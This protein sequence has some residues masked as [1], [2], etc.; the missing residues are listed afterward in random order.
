MHITCISLNIFE[1]GLF[2]PQV[3][4]F[5]QTENPDIIALQEV[6]NEI[7]P[8]LPANLRTIQELK[9]MLPDFYCHFAPELILTKDKKKHV[10][11]N[12]IL[13]RF[14]IVEDSTTFY[15]IPFGE[16]DVNN[17][18]FAQSPKNIHCAKIK[19]N[20][21]Y[22]HVFNT[23]GIW[24]LD[25]G[26]NERRLT[27]SKT[28]INEIKGKENV[29][30]AGDFNIKPHTQTIANIEKELKNVFKDELTSTFN[31]KHKTNPGYASAVVDMIFVSPNMKVMNHYCP[32]VDVS[33]HFPLVIHVEI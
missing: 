18:D 24:G 15:D 17:S 25:G 22:L 2:F 11:G 13:S 28:I 23:H 3:K 30:L 10:L 20:S 5:L 4:E 9:K 12:A 27:M 29:I 6:H 7:D 19:I 8:L 16:Y 26:D 32:Q 31:M 14:P 21:A 1:G 33:D